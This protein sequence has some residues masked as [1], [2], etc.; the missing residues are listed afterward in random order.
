[1]PCLLLARPRPA[2]GRVRSS[3]QQPERGRSLSRRPAPDLEAPKNFAARQ[4]HA[5]RPGD[6]SRSDGTGESDGN[7]LEL[8]SDRYSVVGGNVQILGSAFLGL[9][10]QCARCP[11][12]EFEPVTQE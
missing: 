8:K 6:R 11:D 9:T 2:T 10:I 3:F 7:P 5:L 12:H 4:P 1:M